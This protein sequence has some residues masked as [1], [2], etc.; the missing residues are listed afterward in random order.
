MQTQSADGPQFWPARNIGEHAYCPRLFFYMQVEGV[1]IPS[2]DTIEGLGVHA[3]VDTPTLTKRASVSRKSEPTDNVEPAD[4]TAPTVARSLVLSSERL[5]LTATLDL[6][7]INGEA[8]RGGTAVP[9]EYRKGRPRRV[10]PNGL[11]DAPENADGDEAGETD[12]EPWPTDRVQVGLQVLLLEEAGYHV[13][14]AVLYYAAEK[15]RLT[16]AVDDRLRADAMAELEAAKRTAG[17]TRPLPLVDD[18]KCPKCSLQPICLPDEVNFTRLTPICVDGQPLNEA[19]PPRKMWPLRDDGIHVVAQT[20]GVKVGIR[21]GSLRF[22]DRD[23]RTVRE[24]PLASLESL[25][26]VGSVQVSTQ[27]LHTLADQGIR[28]VYMT[29]AGRCVAWIDPPGSTSGSLKIAQVARLTDKARAVELSKALVAAKIANQRTLLLRN[30]ELT[31]E[32]AADE[33]RRCASLAATATD[34]GTLLGYEGQA[35]AVYFAH[36]G[37]MIRVDDVRGRFQANGRKRRPPPD[38]LNALLSFAYSMLVHEC[39]SALRAAGLEPAIGAYHST[40]PGKPALALDLMEPFRPLIADSVAISMIN[41][42]EVGEGHFLDTAAGCALTEY[43]RRAFFDAW[44]R[45]MSTEVTHPE[46]EYRLSYRR[47]LML[48]ARLIA[49]WIMGEAP[50]LSFLTTR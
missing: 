29:G 6:A 10:Y 18:P 49:A 24:M 1:F 4:S 19:K 2:S 12:V 43:G 46:F 41:R 8:F 34:A 15:R 21:G 13:P 5:E 44:G 16:L 40:R 20:D 38:P 35:A 37:C 50:S 47:M 39:V 36:F 25:A 27:A 42:G 9:V 17:G 7:E 33:L 45:R 31:D 32:S 30:A 26:V 11:H 14:N 23:G 3:R 48:H 22:A 28:V